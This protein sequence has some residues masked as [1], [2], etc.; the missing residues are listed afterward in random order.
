MNTKIQSNSQLW[1]S[2]SKYIAMST[3]CGLLAACNLTDSPS[4]KNININSS[5]PISNVA[6][7]L[8]GQWQAC[9]GGKAW[10]GELKK[11]ADTKVQMSPLNIKEY[12]N[13]DCT[14][15]AKAVS[16]EKVKKFV[17]KQSD[18]AGF[19]AW[20]ANL[21]KISTQKP[22]KENN[23]VFD[24]GLT[25]LALDIY[26][27]KTTDVSTSGVIEVSPDGQSLIFSGMELKRVK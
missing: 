3:L 25:S 7:S 5:T 24:A 19:F 18:E 8:A 2:K 22:Q 12:E 13:K 16:E 6:Q 10:V 15:T 1:F 9:E 21:Q 20:S 17:A 14:G 26:T 4:S 11:V 23:L 27:G